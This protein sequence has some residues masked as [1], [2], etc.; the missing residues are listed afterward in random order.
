[1]TDIEKTVRDELAA[2]RHQMVQFQLAARGLTDQRV[3][4]A[5]A[6]VPR[7]A[8]VPE[9]LAPY[10]YEDRPLPIQANQTISQPYIVALMAAA[11]ELQPEDRVLEIGTGS[12]YAAAVLAGM[13]AEVYT[14]ERFGELAD[15]ARER[16]KSLGYDNVH[17]RQGDG[18]LGWPEHA[19]YD[20]IVVAAAAPEVPEPL[21]QQL[22]VG[23]RLVIP[24]GATLETQTLLRIRRIDEHHFEQD[25]LGG[26]RFVPLIGEAGWRD[27]G[28]TA[29]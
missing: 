5:L 14:V 10:A 18:T 24:V 4:D 27:G 23:G 20:G 29:R 3:L 9:E 8:F 25:D 7:E 11:L 22:A 15:S 19:P 6:T 2:L 12:G 21:K 17:V 16:L 28:H 26:V 1:M 13:C